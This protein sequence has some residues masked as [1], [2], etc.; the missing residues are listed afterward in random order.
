MAEALAIAAVAV[1]S[2]CAVVLSAAETSLTRLRQSR[3][4]V[5]LEEEPD[6]TSPLGWLL[7]RRRQVLGLVLGLVLASHL[8]VATLV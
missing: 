1:L 2:L 8:G 3:A 7:E 4:R 6:E 5:L